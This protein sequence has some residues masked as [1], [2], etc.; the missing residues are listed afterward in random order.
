MVVGSI[1]TLPAKC[2][3]TVN[4]SVHGLTLHYQFASSVGSTLRGLMDLLEKTVPVTAV[5]KVT[6][7]GEASAGTSALPPFVKIDGDGK[8]PSRQR[9][10]VGSSEGERRYS[11]PEDMGSIPI[12]HC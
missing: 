6:E 4:A 3:G 11:V 9:S 1:P 5:E 8:N 10:S 7:I 12:L 2:G